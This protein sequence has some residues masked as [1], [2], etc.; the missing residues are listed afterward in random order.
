MSRLDIIRA[1]KDEAYRLSLS[2][3]ERAQLPEH[4]AGLIELL[5]EEMGAVAGG[6]CTFAP[7][8]NTMAPLCTRWVC[9][10]PGTRCATLECCYPVP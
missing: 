1:W 8:C 3:T 10:E 6:L 5:D 7:R 4:P 2:E 9:D